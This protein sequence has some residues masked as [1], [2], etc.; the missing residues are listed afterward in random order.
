[1][2]LHK[3]ANVAA[4]GRTALALAI[5]ATLVVG[6]CTVN[7]VSRIGK[8]FPGFF[9]W[10]NLF[11][12]AVGEPSWTGA[13]SGLRYQSWLL[14]V[15]GRA[16]RDAH[17]VGDVL[18]G[19]HV[20]D[21][22]TY[23][24]EKNGERYA[25]RI[26]TMAL[27]PRVWISVLG[28]YVLDA[29]VLLVAGIVV[30]YLKPTDPAARALFY[31]STNLSL[32]IATSADLFG[33]YLFRVVY[34]FTLN[35]IPVSVAWLLCEFPVDR[36]RLPRERSALG[37]LLAV[38]LMLG[39]ASNL[40]FFRS[41]GVLLTIDAITH[42]MLAAA[43]LAAIVFFCWHFAHTRSALTRA[44]TQVVL[45][46]TVGAFAPPVIALAVVFL[47]GIPVA[48]NF[49]TLTFVLFPLSIAYAIARHD[50]FDVDRIIR[51]TIV[52]AV[53]SALVFGT[54]S[55]GIGVIDFFFE[56]MT[57]VGSRI[58][59]GVLILILVLA[60]TPSRDRIQNLVDRLYDR[61]RYQYRDVVRT[62][63]KTFTTIL[64]FEQLVFEALT[65]IDRTLQP[66]SAAVYTADVAGQARLR[67]RM[68][69][70]P[71]ESARI[72]VEPDDPCSIDLGPGMPALATLPVL[73]ADGATSA[74]LRAGLTTLL[75]DLEAVLVVPMTLEG[76]LVGLLATAGKRSGG[77][78]NPDD[79]ELART[80]CD[81]LAVALENA[82]AY[83]T[84]DL[85]NVDLEAKNVALE[86]ANR[87]LR[88]T[89]DEL[90]R[91][92]RLAAVGEL[93]GAVAHAIRNPLAGIKAA[94]QLASLDLDGHVA[95]ESLRDVISETDRL[96]ERIGALLQFS[97]PFEPELRATSAHDIVMQAVRDTAARAAARGIVVRTTFTPDVPDVSADPVL[98]EQAVLELLSNAID[99]T[100]DAGVIDVSVSVEHG[101]DGAEVRIEVVDSGAGINEH[102]AAR[103]FDLFY[104]TKPRGTGFGLATV[105]KIIERHGGRISAANRQG[106][107]AAFCISLPAA[108]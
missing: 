67:G 17:E 21:E 55:L 50:L 84:I 48:L 4:P 30:V 10:E 59:Q 3:A 104:T 37:A 20:G 76:R 15:D 57:Q 81:Q 29:L 19:R 88:E 93:A 1:M 87:E 38:S 65:L 27:E 79:Y 53:L 63:S 6:V 69:H 24:F 107:G 78:Y 34:F 90:V 72:V 100:P 32:Y 92:E 40:A 28:L 74:S 43:G 83:Q 60:T 56:N 73:S 82:H 35:L 36:R 47:L 41:R 108:S 96:D 33:P 75:R 99:A 89:Q 42:S 39:A 16:V 106:R 61:H 64:D 26:A 95:A 66:T 49:A 97:R 70:A 77:A 25:T 80:I 8:T 14:E 91:K 62:A 103:I 2:A 18:A 85:L 5:A 54:Y 101:H 31:F 45:L 23:T 51:R 44:R 102:A 11:V 7:A 68:T 86:A 98:I 105:K 46:G 13:R 58:A 52:Y 22:L 71:G 12:P 94:A 9:L